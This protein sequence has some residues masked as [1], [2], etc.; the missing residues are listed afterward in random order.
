MKVGRL[1]FSTFSG[2]N[3]MF[4]SNM[5]HLSI[6]FSSF[7]GKYFTSD[8]NRRPQAPPRRYLLPAASLFKREA[9][10]RVT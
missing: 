3:R 7:G 9:R 10:E 2:I 4:W 8:L 1:C 5:K 6:E